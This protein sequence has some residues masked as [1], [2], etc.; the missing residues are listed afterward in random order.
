MIEHKIM[1]NEQGSSNYKPCE[2]IVLFADLVGASEVSN[3]ISVENYYFTYLKFFHD[4]IEYMENVFTFKSK[5][6]TILKYQGDEAYLVWVIPEC[7]ECEGIEK[8]K[9]QEESVSAILNTLNFAFLLKMYWCLSK[10]NQERVKDN[11]IPK[12]IAIGINLGKAIYSEKFL[13]G[14]NQAR[15]EKIEGYTINIAKRTE[16]EARKGQRSKIYLTETAVKRLENR[17]NEQGIIFSKP[18]PLKFKN[19]SSEFWGYE[20]LAIDP[21]RNPLFYFTF[22][23]IYENMDLKS[24]ILEHIKNF[25]SHTPS[26]FW[27]R[28][29]VRLISIVEDDG[30]EMKYFDYDGK[31]EK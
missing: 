4:A 31:D 17:E 19:I 20:I 13:D 29:V 18:F 15:I 12:E 3:N 7:S 28:E 10:Y 2:A 6:E 30:N 14:E 9:K 21:V 16:G 25:A 5:R 22:K 24:E 23:A 8:N 26:N 11:M 1:Q 27:M